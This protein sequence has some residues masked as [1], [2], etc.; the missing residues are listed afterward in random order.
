[1]ISAGSLLHAA[2]HGPVD[3]LRLNTY[4][5]NQEISIR[6]NYVCHYL[7]QISRNLHFN[8]YFMSY[9]DCKR[10]SIIYDAIQALFVFKHITEDDIVD[11]A[12]LEVG[13]NDIK[14]LRKLSMKNA[15]KIYKSMDNK[16]IQEYIKNDLPNTFCYEILSIIIASGDRNTFESVI[17]LFSSPKYILKSFFTGVAYRQ[18]SIEWFDYLIEK[19]QYDPRVYFHGFTENVEL[20]RNL[21]EC[22]SS[23]YDTI[24]K[25]CPSFAPDY[26]QS[27]IYY[28]IVFR[29][30]LYTYKQLKAFP[31][32]SQL[33]KWLANFDDI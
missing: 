18:E 26:Y 31:M 28:E 3:N 11:Y 17:T 13:H 22:S 8:A 7:P 6:W 24:L 23:I 4:T 27:V 20:N 12:L 21:I 5:G 30:G 10:K 25:H 1:M 16:T 29:L 9:M 15:V 14:F 32:N 19:T 33:E 2:I